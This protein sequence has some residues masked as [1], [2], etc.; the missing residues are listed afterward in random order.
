M[1]IQANKE[2]VGR[3]IAGGDKSPATV[4]RFVDDQSLKD[5]IALF[6]AAF[7]GYRLDIED[8]VAEGDLVAIRA[9][10]HGTHKGTF[11]GI[12]PTGRD[13]SMSAMVFYRIANGRI[14]QFW[15]NADAVSLLQQLGAIPASEAA[16]A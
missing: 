1:S 3:Y 15:L 10:F 11:Q 7:P 6:E 9:L 13:V 5:H 8:M 16:P 14:A 12:A 2:F 4:D